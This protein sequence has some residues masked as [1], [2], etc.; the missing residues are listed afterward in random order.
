M[1]RDPHAG[2]FLLRE[3]VHRTTS[4]LRP[5][6]SFHLALVEIGTSLQNWLV[7]NSRDTVS[8]RKVSWFS[9][10]VFVSVG[11]SYRIS[12]ISVTLR[13]VK[14][15]KHCA[16]DFGVLGA[17]RVSATRPLCPPYQVVRP[18]WHSPPS[19]ECKNKVLSVSAKYW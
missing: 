6:I 12:F 9:S 17:N 8:R 5:A 3:D 13:R 11:Q 18:T 14:Y 7:L 10:V 15:A 2:D 16:L 1:T 19:L 4:D